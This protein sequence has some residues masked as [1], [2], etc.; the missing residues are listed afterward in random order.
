MLGPRLPV[1]RSSTDGRPLDR[2]LIV[3]VPA[4]SQRKHEFVSQFNLHRSPTPLTSI[5]S[6]THLD[7]GSHPIHTYTNEWT[8]TASAAPF[9]IH[10]P[11][12]PPTHS[13]PLTLHTLPHEHAAVV[14]ALVLLLLAAA[15]A[16][17]KNNNVEDFPRRR[18]RPRFVVPEGAWGGRAEGRRRR[19][20]GES[21]CGGSEMTSWSTWWERLVV[22]VV[23]RISWYARNMVVVV[24]HGH[25]PLPNLTDY[26]SV[27]LRLP[28]VLPMNLFNTLFDLPLMAD[29]SALQG[30]LTAIAATLQQLVGGQS[31][32][33]SAP[34]STAASAPAPPAPVPVLPTPSVVPYTSARAQAL[35][36]SSQGHPV[37]T[38]SI[39]SHQPIL[40]MAGLGLNLS[41]NSNNAR[42]SGRASSQ[43]T[44]SQISQTNAGRQSAIAAHFPPPQN[45]APRRRRG[46][47]QPTPTL[48]ARG[49]PPTLLETV[50]FVD[51]AGLRNLRVRVK[52]LPH[53]TLNGGEHVLARRLAESEDRFL[54]EHNLVHTYVVSETTSVTDLIRMTTRSLQDG[55]YR[56]RFGSANGPR[57]SRHLPHENL[58]LY[59]LS[60]VNKGT[61]RANGVSYLTRYPTRSICWSRISLHL[62][63]V[64][65]SD[66]LLFV[67][68]T[69]M[70]GDHLIVRA[71][72][73][74]PEVQFTAEDEGVWPRTHSCLSLRHSQYIDEATEGDFADSDSTDAVT[75]G[76]EPEAA[77]DDEDE[78]M[79]DVRPSISQPHPISLPTQRAIASVQAIPREGS[80]QEFGVPSRLFASPFTPQ[81]GPHH[82]V[83]E[84]AN[85]LRAV[86]ERANGGTRGTPFVVEGTDLD[87][88]VASLKNAVGEAVDRDDFT[89]I[90][91]PRRDFRK[92]ELCCLLV[93]GVEREV[94]HALYRSFAQRPEKYFVPREGGWH[95]IATTISMSQRFLVSDVRLREL[96]IL[97]AVLMLMLLHGMAPDIVSPAL[98]QF[99]FHGCDLNALT[100]VFLVEWYPVLSLLIDDW[101]RNGPTG[102]L[103]RFRSHFATHHDMQ[104]ATLE[105][106]NEVQH[107][108]LG[109]DMLYVPI[110]GPHPPSHPENKSVFKGMEMRCRNGFNMFEASFLSPSRNWFLSL[111]IQIWAS[112]VQDFSSLEP[113]LDIVCP[114]ARDIAHAMINLPSIV[115]L[116]AVLRGFFSRTG[117]PCPGRFEL[118]KPAI[119]PI[120]PLSRIDSPSF[121]PQMFV[122]AATGAPCVELTQG[123]S[124]VFALPS[125][126]DYDMD[127]RKRAAGMAEGT[128]A[129]RSCLRSAWLPLSHL[130]KLHAASYPAR[131]EQGNAV[132]PLTLEDALDDWMLTQIVTA[133]GDLT[134][135]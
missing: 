109:A 90:L 78:N 135:L 102:D 76:G 133:I 121:R 107:Q 84:A 27:P 74:H 79:P 105:Q 17:V 36:P 60:L 43:L 112:R 118:I 66:I 99:A 77:S 41:G 33:A 28:M 35:P 101:L 83:F 40:G 37:S 44:A 65:N 132:E 69:R 23:T 30:T 51:A 117:I 32:S 10:P 15:T 31:A 70:R 42:V 85:F 116:T 61:P 98:F 129:F 56:Y 47:A 16:A 22:V 29:F 126:T 131:D 20:E 7:P 124:A 120:V 26:Y 5:A 12:P 19:R 114:S 125:N 123:V 100:H 50:S 46:A 82:N 54:S 57:A 49:P 128:I 134:V 53:S 88:M 64:R 94:V 68:S 92:T 48:P 9:T 3:A 4:I 39:S 103:R 111:F 8:T 62:E 24:H 96:K 106:L 63:T 55:P 11:S 34:P 59:V 130:V 14:D 108:A 89:D 72:I 119:H 93:S 127:E 38:A 87:S 52:I 86:G 81:P 80:L 6:S 115:N 71:A 21:G 75:S 122:W 91:S 113:N 95:G 73:R 25:Q 45:L 58:S 1:V 18:R 110:Y 97:G 13:I 2:P 104:I 67:W